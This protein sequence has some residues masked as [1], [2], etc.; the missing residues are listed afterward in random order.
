ME[1]YLIW[2]KGPRLEYGHCTKTGVKGGNGH[3]IV[4]NKHNQVFRNA[5]KHC[6]KDL[7][8]LMHGWEPQ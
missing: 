4:L 8:L 5:K 7:D 6:G 2:K 3:N 1:K